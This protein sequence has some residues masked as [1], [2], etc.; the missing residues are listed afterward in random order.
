[1]APEQIQGGEVDARSDIFSFGVVLFEMLTG[2]FPFRGEHEAAM[3]YSIVNEE[4]EPIS[5]YVSAIPPAVQNVLE[6]ALEKDPA[7]RY[8]S[9][10]E[11]VVDLRRTRKQTT[12]VS[13]NIPTTS[14]SYQTTE[15]PQ[16]FSSRSNKKLFLTIGAAVLIVVAGAVAYFR[17]FVSHNEVKPFSNVR[18]SALT[19]DGKVDDQTISSDGRYVAYVKLE[20]EKRNIWI[21]QVATTSNL[22]ITEPTEDGIFSPAFSPSGDFLYYL[23]N[24]KET[25]K[26]D[27][28]QITTLGGTQRM[29]REQ[30]YSRLAFSPDGKQIAFL[31]DSLEIE[32]QLIIADL[33]GMNETI[34]CRRK[35][36]NHFDDLSWSP[37]GSTI[38]LIDG[39]SGNFLNHR[40]MLFSINDRKETILPN[41]QW[42]SLTGVNW[43]AN[44]K[45]LIVT[46]ADHQSSF[47]SHQIWFVPYPNGEP[48]RITNDMNDY[49]YTTVDGRST[50]MA[51]LASERYANL[52]VAQNNSAAPAQ[53]LTEGSKRQDGIH[54]VR[55]LDNGRIV[56]CSRAGGFDNI[57]TNTEQGHAESQI[58]SGSF[59]DYAPFPSPD[60]RFL[61][62]YSNRGGSFNIWRCDING[63]NLK[64]LTH[65]VFDIEPWISP[66]GRWIF[67]VAYGENASTI[68]KIT[69]DGDSSRQIV[70][71]QLASYALSADGNYLAYGYFNEENK[72]KLAIFSLKTEEVVKELDYSFR[73]QRW[74]PD[75]KA[76]AYVKNKNGVSNIWI[77]PIDGSKAKQVTEFASEIIFSFDWSPDGKKLVVARGEGNTDVVLLTD[78]DR[79]P[80]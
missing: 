38:A 34:I 57:W 8:Q 27:L 36:P 75:S 46:A 29:I 13:G 37:D 48:R 68:R 78:L 3:M 44:G 69:I 24:K 35:I 32:Y 22:P 80:Q 39:S 76:I 5:K 52:W 70:K 14:G 77:Q 6:K 71:K 67:Y 74:T 56:Y 16:V 65:G 45:G 23:V 43:L 30:V 50:A 2:R 59:G 58:T 15:P 49:F 47:D 28:Y 63:S 53:Q 17:F 61:V 66:D 72:Q 54:G 41:Q 73:L 51:A 7:S 33:N 55:W 9:I 25:N 4:P 64:Q 12:R 26:S 20:K 60:K 1:M 79:I 31:R 10:G 19:S 62:F 42:L 11:M 18:I 40:V 21:R